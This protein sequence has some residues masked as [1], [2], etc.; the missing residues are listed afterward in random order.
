MLLAM[1]AIAILTVFSLEFTYQSR[2]AVRTSSYVESE[3]E[4]YL[5][6]RAAVELAKASSSS[7]SIASRVDSIYSRASSSRSRRVKEDEGGPPSPTPR[8]RGPSAS[9]TPRCTGPRPAC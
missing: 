6:A 3:I 5:H 2:V 9:S 4:A 7:R 1:T 8:G